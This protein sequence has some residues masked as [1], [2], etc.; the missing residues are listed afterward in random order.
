MYLTCFFLR[1]RKNAETEVFIEMLQSI[2]QILIFPIDIDLK[3]PLCYTI[4]IFGPI[5][6]ISLL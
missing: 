1:I 6:G 5:P 2:R 4:P 3:I